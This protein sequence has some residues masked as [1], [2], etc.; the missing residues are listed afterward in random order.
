MRLERLSLTNFRS[1]ARLESDIPNGIL[2][3]RGGNAVGK[4]SILESLFYC[5]TFSTSLAGQDRQLIRFQAEEEDPAVARIVAAY[6]VG[7]KKRKLEIRLILEGERETRRL[8][9]EILLDGRKTTA[10]SAVGEFPAV[11][12]LPQMTEMISGPPAERRRYLNILLSQSVPGYART[13]SRYARAVLQR[14][15]LL[16]TLNERGGDPG[17]L[18]YWD[19]LLA[20]QGAFLIY[21][22]A[23]AIATLERLADTALQRLT[24]RNEVMS[25]RY[26]PALSDADLTLTELVGADGKAEPE[27]IAG[28]TMAVRTALESGRRQDIRRGVSTIG[29]HRDEMRVVT[30]G[31]DVGVYGSR[32]QVRTVL[33][34]LKFAEVDWIREAKGTAPLLL[35]DETFSELDAGRRGELMR[36]L[37]ECGQGIVTT[38]D[39]KFFSSEFLGS[40]T[41]WEVRDG[42]LL[43]E[44]M[45]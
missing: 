11:L 24:G 6:A 32:G 29:P 20:G 16:R 27:A 36:L 33:L 44:G 38:T 43:K 30:N 1:Y 42:I 2:L 19:E 18:A 31:I 10:Q 45:V 13:L 14:N 9:K 15:A 40:R 39:L 21:H 41:I 4:T 22:R 25:L 5:A 37:D 12:F 3:L 23:R 28:I 26:R 8:R 35:L 7:E 34:A 17:Q